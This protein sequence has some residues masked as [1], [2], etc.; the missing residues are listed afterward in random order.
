MKSSTRTS[1]RYSPGGQATDADPPPPGRSNTS[2]PAAMP[3]STGRASIH[4]SWSPVSN[5]PDP[6]VLR[7]LVER[8]RHAEGQDRL[9]LPRDVDR[10]HCGGSAGR[11]GPLLEIGVRSGRAR[12]RGW[13]GQDRI[14]APRVTRG[15]IRPDVGPGRRQAGRDVRPGRSCRDA[16]RRGRGTGGGSNR[17][18]RG[19]V[20]PPGRGSRF[21]RLEHGRGQGDRDH[22][23][24]DQH[25]IDPPT[26][27]SKPDRVE[28]D[29]H[30][31]T[32]SRAGPPASGTTRPSAS[33]VACRRRRL[34]SAPG[35]WSRA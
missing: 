12:A 26:T 27:R 3:P 16:G 11:C 21:P 9:V 14:H 33:S 22:D 25:R 1:I 17:C 19:G 29:A 15:D 32:V 30:L 31:V 7:H 4:S 18:R 6:S 24:A 20:L 2:E 5:P 13:A 8:E 28:V 35:T 10:V 23:H 34:S